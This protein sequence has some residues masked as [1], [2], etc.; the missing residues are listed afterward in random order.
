MLEKIKTFA[1]DWICRTPIQ[2]FPVTVRKGVAKGARWTV[3]PYSAYWRGHTEDDIESAI[4]LY[5]N[6]PGGTCWDLGTHFGIYTVGMAMAVGNEGQ[7]AGFEPDPVSFKRCQRHIQMNSLWWV[8]L[9]N[10][11]ASDADGVG[12]FIVSCSPGTSTSH[13]AY[14]DETVKDK[15]A[16]VAVPMILLDN[17]VDRG[18]IRPPQF[19]KVDVEGHGARALRGGRNTIAKHRPVIVMSFH[20]KWE[21]DGTVEVLAPLGYRAFTSEGKELDWQSAIYRTAVLRDSHA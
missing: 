20:S 15:D 4:R 16:R 5:G 8:K 21:L 19:I 11:A 13:F 3:L 18:D 1:S 9:I 12:D 2:Y 10:A 6:I 17:L 14:E 7:V